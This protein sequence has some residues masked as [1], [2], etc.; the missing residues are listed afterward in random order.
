MKSVIN[1]FPFLFILTLFF[2]YFFGLKGI[3][4]PTFIVLIGIFVVF[5]KQTKFSLPIVLLVFSCIGSLVSSSYFRGTSPLDLIREYNT[6]LSILIF[7]LLCEYRPKTETVENV[8]FWLFICFSICYIIQC[9]VYPVK[10]FVP[11]GSEQYSEF[12]GYDEIINRRI[13]LPGMSIVGLGMFFCLNKIMMGKLYY[14]LPFVLSVIVLFLFG[15][16]T[17]IFFAMIWSVILYFR[18]NGLSKRLMLYGAGGIIA[19]YIF[20]TTDFAQTVINTML[21]RNES[22]NFENQDYIRYATLNYFTTQ[23]FMSPLEFFFG[24]GLPN[25]S[26]HVGYTSYY[27]KLEG[28]GLHFYDWGLLG[29]SWMTGV[30]SLV[31]CLWYSIK[32]IF[33][34]LPKTH[35]Y[36]SVWFAYLLCSAFTSA[37]FVRQGCFYIQGVAL[38]LI[39][40]ISKTK[41]HT[42]I[43]I[44]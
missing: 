44:Q 33:A 16:R 42:T 3:P 34:K 40:Q 27:N 15:F 39:W 31:G 18:V 38:Y 17:T 21:T 41:N 43:S 22:A 25:R 10:I 13:R 9:I 28:M 14:S 26:I 36:L 30:L 37:E 11:E 7:F 12:T 2:E 6:Y 20:V 19:L 32:A 5:Y 4:S 24:S 35:L 29:I 1:T 8:L 23:H